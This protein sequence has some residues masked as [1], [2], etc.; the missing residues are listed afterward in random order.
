MAAK[1]EERL[2]KKRKRRRR[3]L[4]VALSLLPLL[5]IAAGVLSYW[6]FG[7]SKITTPR[8]IV[9]RSE[10]AEHFIVPPNKLNILVMG[11]DDR[12]RE[13][14]PGRSDTLLVMTIDTESR[15]ASII[16]IPRDTRVRVKGLGWDKI[17]HAYL[18][19]KEALTRQTTESFLGIPMDYY[20]KVNL[21]SFGRIVDAIGG[22]T[23]D[24]EKRMQYEDSW[25]HYVIDLQPGVQRL[26][27]RTALQY[28]RYRDED[29]DIGRVA[30]QQKFIKAVLAE[31]S[32]PAI[33][34]KAPSIIREIFASLDTDMP[35]GLMLGVAR[36][37]KNGLSGGFK[38]HMVEGL[39]YYIN[40]ISYWVPDIM[41]LRRVVADMQGVP[42]TGVVEA[43]ARRADEEYRNAFPANAHL[44]DGTYYPGMDKDKDKAKPLKPGEKP[45]VKTP[46][47]PGTVAPT[48]PGAT[49]PVKPGATTPAKPAPT[50]PAKPAPTKPGATPSTST[51]PVRLA[52]ELV[53][54][55][56]QAEASDRIA[57][58]MENR[59][60]EVSGISTVN[61]IRTTVVTSYTQNPS[62]VAKLTDLPFKYVLNI[63]EASSRPIPVRVLIGQDYGG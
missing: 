40:D 29:G 15:E 59:G 4:W 35:V 44:D 37:F 28:V 16:S 50:T 48:K 33:I 9:K 41:K 62:V 21:D 42:F 54:A 38:T 56:G 26:D 55:S 11:V 20:V 12:P 25:D 47:K 27:G 49:T 31:A 2:N 39:P 13:D 3:N 60:F 57:S 43:A 61:P 24:V 46:L 8:V 30:R 63:A 18:I 22:V 23:V 14:D 7:S 19:G 51:A 53:N 36:Q 45:P 52:T 5:L 17:N 32:S 58:I 1:L 6:W 10:E 34:L